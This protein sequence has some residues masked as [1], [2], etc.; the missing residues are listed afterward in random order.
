MKKI[1]C[2]LILCGCGFKPMFSG[3]D[4]D[5]YV[6]VISGINGIELRNALTTKFG[7]PRSSDAPYKLV[8]TLHDPTTKYKAIEKSGAATWQEIN[9]RANYVLSYRDK[10]IAYGKETASESYTFVQYLVAANASYNNA[11]AD[12]ITVLA[13]KIGSR[14][15]AEVYKHENKSDKK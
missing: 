6:P 7:G 3:N 9:L 10:P 1:L 14:A 5:I 2:F 12:T 8:V 13:D 15:I 11:V 4:T